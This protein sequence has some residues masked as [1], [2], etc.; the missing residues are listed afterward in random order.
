MEFNPLSLNTS[1]GF[2]LRVI[3]CLKVREKTSLAKKPEA[4][5][6]WIAHRVKHVMISTYFVAVA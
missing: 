6:T 1:L 4:N 5:S 3:K 2:P